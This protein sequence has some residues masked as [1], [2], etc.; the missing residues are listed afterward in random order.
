MRIEIDSITNN[1]SVVRTLHQLT[2]GR[3]RCLKEISRAKQGNISDF[4][5]TISKFIYDLRK[6]TLNLIEFHR[7]WINSLNSKYEYNYI[8]RIK[9]R[10]YLH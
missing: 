10:N 9:D 6:L 1:K 2:I 3:E 7:K 5:K 8:W 4:L